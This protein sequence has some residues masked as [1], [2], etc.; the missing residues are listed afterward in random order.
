MFLHLLMGFSNG[1]IK[2]ETRLFIFFI[3]TINFDDPVEKAAHDR[4]VALVEKMID[5]KKTLAHARTD[6]DRAIYERLTQSLD[7][8]IDDLVYHLYDITPEERKIIEGN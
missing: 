2:V 5:A 1:K 6:A 4:I 3:R 8:Q 7:H